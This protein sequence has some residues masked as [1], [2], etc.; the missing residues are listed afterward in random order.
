MS[1][2]HLLFFLKLPKYN[3]A[4]V[5]LVH[6]VFELYRQGC[7]ALLMELRIGSVSLAEAGTLL[8]ELETHTAGIIFNSTL[9]KPSVYTEE[10]AVGEAHRL[11]HVVFSES[12]RMAS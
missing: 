7:G 9:G 10:K 5:A 6:T 4:T 2:L 8:G 12:L 1:L 11:Y 3:F